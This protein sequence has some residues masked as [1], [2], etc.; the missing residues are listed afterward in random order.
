MTFIYEPIS[1]SQC[2][3]NNNKDM[4]LKWTPKNDTSETLLVDLP[5]KDK[6]C[7]IMILLDAVSKVK[8]T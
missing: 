8:F 1:Y 6:L 7:R 4:L 3:P 2:I 5:G